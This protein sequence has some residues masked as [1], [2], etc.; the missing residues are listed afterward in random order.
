MDQQESPS[1]EAHEPTEGS[2]WAQPPRPA[3]TETGSDH[4]PTPDGFH[5][6]I[7]EVGSLMRDPFL[8]SGG[9]FIEQV[10]AFPTQGWQEV[11]EGLIY[12]LSA[13]NVTPRCQLGAQ[14]PAGHRGLRA[15]SPTGP[16]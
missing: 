3:E 10:A 4:P 11:G 1:A 5:S 14:P 12:T 8:G 15:V 2:A 9:R 7:R 6:K 13:S 16:E